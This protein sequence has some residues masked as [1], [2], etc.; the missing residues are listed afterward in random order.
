MTVEAYARQLLQ[1]LPRG[2]AWEVEPQ[3][4]RWRLLLGIAEE[5]ARVDARA[6]VLVDE[7]DPRTTSELLTD[8]ERVFGLPDPC[9]G[10]DLTLAQ[11][12]AALLARYTGLGGQTPAYFV[13][14]AAALG[15]TV[16]ITEFRPYSVNDSVDTPL[17]DDPWAYAWQVNAPLNT[18]GEFTVDTPVSEPLAWWGN[19][20]LECVLTRLKPAH[21]RVLFAYTAPPEVSAPRYMLLLALTSH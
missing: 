9:V 3:D 18:I 7:A 6:G 19:A 17:Y 5:F 13:G 16:T 12:R 8:W 10:S 11:R 14:V 2:A 21:T 4:V 1:L 20:A 15:Y